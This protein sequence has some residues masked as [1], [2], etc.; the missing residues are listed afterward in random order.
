MTYRKF[1]ADYL[2]DGT[3]LLDDKHV[4]VTSEDGTV[5]E[6]A[7]CSDA[8]EDVERFKGLISPGF[9]NCHC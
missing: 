7:D 2:F 4:L 3:E 1:Q 8:G 5:R 6:I 9:I